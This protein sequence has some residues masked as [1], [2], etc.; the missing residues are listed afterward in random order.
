MEKIKRA[1]YFFPIELF[2]VGNKYS[3]NDINQRLEKV[4]ID[5]SKGITE[6]LNCFA[7]VV[8][9]EKT[10]KPKNQKYKDFFKNRKEFFWES[11]QPKSIGG[12]KNKFGS[13]NTPWMISLLNREKIT[14]LFARIINKTKGQTNKFIYCGELEVESYDTAANNLRP[15]GVKFRTQEIPKKIPKDMKDLINWRPTKELSLIEAE[16][17]AIAQPVNKDIDL[18]EKEG[19]QRIFNQKLKKA[20]ELYAMKKAFDYYKSQGYA[21]S[22]VSNK[23]NLGY[24]IL[25]ERPG[26][27]RYVEV[28]GTQNDGWCVFVTH[29]E[30]KVAKA[31][32]VDLFI[33]NNINHKFDTEEL[34]Y[35]CEGGE[36]KIISPWKPNSSK[37][38][39]KAI[40]YKFCPEK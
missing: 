27:T 28:K 23:R 3:R 35:K 30:V 31:K 33:V 32:P 20:I 38:F 8:T 40:E 15:F 37:S 6:F 1:E 34:E 29:N 12:R 18:D 4:T 14:I 24:D 16:H 17:L 21:A 39:L 7:L 9:L 26:S 36:V 13:P 2:A 11:Q 22:D 25:C 10:D 5:A 19:Q